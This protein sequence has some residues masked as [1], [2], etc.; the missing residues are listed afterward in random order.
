MQLF[1]IESVCLK[2]FL[3]SAHTCTKQHYTITAISFTYHKVDK[4]TSQQV[5]AFVKRM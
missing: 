4:G 5:A 2:L 1:S 3:S